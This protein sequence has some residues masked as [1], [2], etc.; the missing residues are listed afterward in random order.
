MIGVWGFRSNRHRYRY[1]YRHQWL[2]AS[3]IE[4]ALRCR[5]LRG[6]S[7][8][9]AVGLLVLLVLIEMLMLMLV[10]VPV[11]GLGLVLLML[12]VMLMLMLVLV[13]LV[14]LLLLVFS[15]QSRPCVPPPHPPTEKTRTA[16]SSDNTASDK[17][18]LEV[19]RSVKTARLQI[20]FPAATVGRCITHKTGQD[21]C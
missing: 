9:L 3:L 5:R 8:A 15:S 20:R 4:M 17:R 6:V 18:G 14:L 19:S 10:P 7:P 2:V 11:L 13:L 12:V 1:R 16:R 21:S